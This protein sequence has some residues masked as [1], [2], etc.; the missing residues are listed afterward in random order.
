[1]TNKQEIQQE[2]KSI[3]K[4]VAFRLILIAIF[5]GITALDGII[6]PI[7]IGK[8]MDNISKKEFSTSFILLV[9][10]LLCFVLVNASFWIWRLLSLNIRK[11]INKWLR[12]QA[13]AN[14]NDHPQLQSNKIFKFYQCHDQTI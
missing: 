13:V 2:N 4:M 11:I 14:Y 6:S 3:K 9:V 12:S 5:G 1:M 10:F 7:L 8:L